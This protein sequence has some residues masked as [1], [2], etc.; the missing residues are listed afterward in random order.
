LPC[1]GC[2]EE[3]TG[4]IAVDRTEPSLRL[5]HAP[6]RRHH[7]ARRFLGDQ[8]RVINLAG[9]VVQ[10]HNQVVPAVIAKPLV[11]AGIDVQHHSRKRSPRPSPSVRTSPP[12]YFHKSG[13]L[14]RLFHPCIAELDTVLTT[15]LLVKMT[16]IEAGVFFLVQLQHAFGFFNGNSLRTR[17]PPPV[18]QSRIT[19]PLSSSS[20][21]SH[22]PY[23][24]P[25]H[26]GLLPPRD[27]FRRR[28]LDDFLHFHRSLHCG[29]PI[30]L[31]FHVPSVA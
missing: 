17:M 1:L 12:L 28:P 20:P 31:L 5:G 26:L 30:Q 3:M 14:Q 11:T 29:C 2:A 22:P 21:S 27:P 9:R 25:H 10:D 16:H 7:R 23:I 18:K 4:A 8:L 13:R 6:Q 24:H 15:K 19:I